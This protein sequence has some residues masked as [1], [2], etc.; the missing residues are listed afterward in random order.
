MI[1][2]GWEG[3]DWFKGIYCGQISQVCIAMYQG[4]H[5]LE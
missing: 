4:C 2:E 5:E 1:R 3:Y